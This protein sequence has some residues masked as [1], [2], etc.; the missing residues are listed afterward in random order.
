MLQNANQRERTP[1]EDILGSLSCRVVRA[2]SRLTSF[3]NSPQQRTRKHITQRAHYHHGGFSAVLSDHQVRAIPPG[4]Y[5]WIAILQ[6]R[7]AAVA[8]ESRAAGRAQSLP[9]PW[10]CADDHSASIVPSARRHFDVEMQVIRWF[11]WIFVHSPL[12]LLLF[13]GVSNGGI[14]Q[15]EQTSR[16]WLYD[17]VFIIQPTGWLR[18]RLVR[19]VL[20]LFVIGVDNNVRG[21]RWRVRLT[22]LVLP[23]LGRYEWLRLK[24]LVGGPFWCY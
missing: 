4:Q 11:Y 22:T 14:I 5:R 16:P 10:R 13:Y 6:I 24:E 7:S 12:I 9:S 8:V 19:E 18:R 2:D 20:L 3:R 17:I 15:Q 1:H 21:I 23:E